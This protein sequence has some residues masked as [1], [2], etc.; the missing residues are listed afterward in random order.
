MAFSQFS[1]L[2]NLQGTQSL[3]QQLELPSLPS[4]REAHLAKP[5]PLLWLLWSRKMRVEMMLLKGTFCSSSCSRP[6]QVRAALL[7]PTCRAS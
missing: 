5:T 3:S 6:C 2:S 7:L 1:L 4:P